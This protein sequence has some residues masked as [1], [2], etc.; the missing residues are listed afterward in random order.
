MHALNDMH[1]HFRQGDV[2]KE[3][4]P[5]TARCCRHAL[6]MPNT[7]PPIKDGEDVGQYRK[8][9]AEA[10]KGYDFTPLMTVKLLPSTK[11]ADIVSAKRAGAVAVKLYVAG[12]T[13]NSDDGM[14]MPLVEQPTPGLRQVFDAMADEGMV[15]CIHAETV[16]SDCLNRERDFMYT[17][18]VER[19][20]EEHPR[21]RVVIEHVTDAV[22][23]NMVRQLA[24]RYPGRVAA[25]ITLHHLFLTLDDVVGQPHNYCKPVA[26][27]QEDRLALQM[28]A[29]GGEPCFFLGSDS[30][31]HPTNRKE[32][33]HSCAGCFTAPVLPELLWKFFVENGA[34]YKFTDFA[35]RSGASFYGLKWDDGPVDLGVVPPLVQGHTVWRKP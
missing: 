35:S 3:V 16:D 24:R 19:V 5:W 34:I 13:T 23:I 29:L 10:A 8:E 12:T 27:L 11:H 4:V 18:H 2:L 22:T 15:Y 21:L 7:D 14:P 25:T 6:V 32:A 26:K 28:A 33:A 30:A 20:L 1:V 17:R 31:P 9:I